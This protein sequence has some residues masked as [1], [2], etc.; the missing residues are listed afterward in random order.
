[1]IPTC[2]LLL[3]Q[4]FADQRRERFQQRPIIG[5]QRSKAV[6]LE[7]QQAGWLKCPQGSCARPPGEQLEFVYHVTGVEFPGGAGRVR[8]L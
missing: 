6:R 8:F 4:A 2:A 3:A 7:L 5:H 1:M